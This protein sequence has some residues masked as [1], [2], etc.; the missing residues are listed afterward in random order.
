MSKER[1]LGSE[2]RLRRIRDFEE[3]SSFIVYSFSN[4]EL[5]YLRRLRAER[6]HGEEKG[7]K[8]REKKG[9]EK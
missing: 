7:E 1:R 9:R 5:G 6:I 2:G 8:E 3:E 4:R